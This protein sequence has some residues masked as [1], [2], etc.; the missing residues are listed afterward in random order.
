[1]NKS[2][3]TLI[4]VLITS[5]I[6]K[7]KISS[8][9]DKL[10]LGQELCVNCSLKSKNG[11]FSLIFQDDGNLVLYKSGIIAKWT[12][13]TEKK[14]T[15]KCIFQ[16]DGNFVL[17]SNNGPL[18]ASMTDGTGNFLILQDDGNL[19]IYNRDNVGI[20]ASN[21]VE[22]IDD[23]FLKK[24]T[25]KNNEISPVIGNPIK[26]GN[27]LIAEHD[28]K[29]K[30][31]WDV[32][33]IACS[34]LGNGWHLPNKDELNELYKHK[35]EI[36]GFTD[37]HYWSSSEYYNSSTI[38]HSWYFPTGES[39]GWKNINNWRVRAVRSF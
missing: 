23:L 4:I 33:K 6:L 22:K 35:Y 14:N 13:K 9:R 34:A 19:V 25:L 27:L 16:N 15:I 32:A 29:M 39:N 12:T 18:W 17:Y 21:T 38:A 31:N 7:A 20:W 24:T 28:F 10:S 26:L 3:I 30:M 11:L 37:D 36:G 2:I 1:M 8:E 5:S